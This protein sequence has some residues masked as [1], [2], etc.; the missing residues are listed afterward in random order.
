MQEIIIV[1]PCFD[2]HPLLLFSVQSFTTDG[3]CGPSCSI[4]GVDLCDETQVKQFSNVSCYF[5]T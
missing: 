2:L 3:V 1:R 4:N 5:N